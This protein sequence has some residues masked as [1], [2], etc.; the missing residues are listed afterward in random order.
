MTVDGSHVLL[1]GGCATRCQ[2]ALE[3]CDICP[4]CQYILMAPVL[5]AP[6][7]PGQYGSK[8][9]TRE[10]S[11]FTYAVTE[12]LATRACLDCTQ[13]IA[14]S[15]ADLSLVACAL[16]ECSFYDGAECVCVSGALLYCAVIA[17]VTS[18][19]TV[20]SMSSSSTVPLVPASREL[21]KPVLTGVMCLGSPRWLPVPVESLR[22]SEYVTTFT[23]CN[24]L[25]GHTAYPPMSLGL[26]G[27]RS[28]HQAEMPTLLKVSSLPGRRFFV[29]SAWQRGA[30]LPVCC[31]SVSVSSAA[32]LR[33]LL[34]RPR[35]LIHVLCSSMGDHVLTLCV[36]TAK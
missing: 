6:N 20:V 27:G 13:L 3:H 15:P 14:R 25:C 23:M 4:L 28:Q 10:S 21:V 17:C 22:F 16:C 9:G 36:V 7:A 24:C 29:S 2:A 35:V 30:L 33:T 31:A 11:I 1:C 19:M 12:N 8:K 32:L 34:M 26:L 18:G 5:H